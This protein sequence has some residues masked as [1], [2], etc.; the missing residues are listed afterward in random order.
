MSL[1]NLMVMFL[2]DKLDL[3]EFHKNLKAFRTRNKKIST[4]RSL[5]IK[6]IELHKV[7]ISDLK[8]LKELS[9]ISSN[10]LNAFVSIS[11]DYFNLS[12]LV[13]IKISNSFDMVNTPPPRDKD[14]LETIAASVNLLEQ[15]IK[16]S[17]QYG[18]THTQDYLLE[19][20]LS[21]WYLL[22]NGEASI[23]K[24]EAIK[25]LI[26]LS[27]NL[28]DIGNARLSIRVLK[29]AEKYLDVKE[30]PE[31]WFELYLKHIQLIKEKN[32]TDGIEEILT[33][34]IEQMEY[35]P[36][37]EKGKK[38]KL[39]IYG[40]TGEYLAKSPD[41]ENMRQAI[42]YYELAANLAKELYGED[43]STGED[44][45]MKMGVTLTK[46]GDEESLIEGIKILTEW[47]KKWTDKLTGMLPKEIHLDE[48]TGAPPMLIS[49]IS[50]RINL[51]DKIMPMVDIIRD[52]KVQTNLDDLP[53]VLEKIAIVFE[54]FGDE[55][56]LSYAKYLYE[57]AKGYVDEKD[58][59]ATYYSI[60]IQGLEIYIRTMKSKKESNE[61]KL[62]ILEFVE[63]LKLIV[64]NRNLQNLNILLWGLRIV[65]HTG[66]LNEIYDTDL[67]ELDTSLSEI[68]E[69]LE[70]VYGISKEIDILSQ[71]EKYVYGLIILEIA[72]IDLNLM[73]LHIG[74]SEVGSNVLDI[75][76]ELEYDVLKSLRLKVGFFVFNSLFYYLKRNYKALNTSLITSVNLYGELL[77]ETKKA[78]KNI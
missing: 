65:K 27:T 12:K 46:I 19:K 50:L 42:H 76:Y 2:E 67:E 40:E 78:L 36:N 10:L 57:K 28:K 62:L 34:L 43:S 30:S 38:L 26:N 55:N 16:L 53:E 48:L 32:I 15:L 33:H 25:S 4:A 64:K 72:E 9:E 60:K 11:E 74:I 21:G 39:S 73:A 1:E 59:Q 54:S 41:P 6:F 20:L 70:A 37:T 49:T 3:D 7:P 31:L 68:T 45:Q 71:E 18:L 47:I 52:L 5:L 58:A 61:V 66:I 8:T 44:I 77:E 24:I 29:E 56:S 69:L 17:A 35:L 23:D 14:E 63:K 75:S 51:L 13:A 22:W